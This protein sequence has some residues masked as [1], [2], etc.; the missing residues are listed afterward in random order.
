MDE[1]RTK[2]ALGIERYREGKA[3]F[4]GGGVSSA[5]DLGYGMARYMVSC[6]GRRNVVMRREFALCLE[7]RYECDCMVEG[8]IHTSAV[9]VAEMERDGYSSHDCAAVVDAVGAVADSVGDMIF[10]HP[11]YDL[12]TRRYG[13]GYLNSCLSVEHDCICGVL[14]EIFARLSE[15]GNII[16][17]VER[18]DASIAVLKD[19]GSLREAIQVFKNEMDAVFDGADADSV[20]DLLCRDSCEQG[21][22]EPFL[23]ELQEDVL[24]EAY[25]KAVERG[26]KGPL[27]RETML[28]RRDYESYIDTS[29]NRLIDL[30][31]V[32]EKI[33]QNEPERAKAFGSMLSKERM[34]HSEFSIAATLL[35]KIGMS[36]EAYRMYEA[37]FEAE[38]SVKRFNHLKKIDGD[39]ARGTLKRCLNGYTKWDTF[40]PEEMYVFAFC[41][42][43]AEVEEYLRTIDF[44]FRGRTIRCNP[45]DIHTKGADALCKT[46]LKNGYDSSSAILARR[47]VELILTSNA[48]YEFP[49]ALSLLRFMDENPE[50]ES[51]VPPHSEFKNDLRNRTRALSSFWNTLDG[52]RPSGTRQGRMR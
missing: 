44:R 15:P 25:R 47:L 19:R 13:W 7:S 46:L 32:I 24:D 34:N 2:Y 14:E 18:I 27:L 10:R 49:M 33:H 5:T 35:E 51:L 37:D 17:T 8:C 52:K 50:Y 11:E 36:E 48:I 9:M 6:D 20:A 41:G 29:P 38:P 31:M 39:R 45:A 30:M 40:V 23:S 12:N 42:C 16:K 28:L 26:S 1:L 22:F 4:D 3:V 43:C 21:W